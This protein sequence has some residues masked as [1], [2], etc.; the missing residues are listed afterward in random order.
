MQAQKKFNQVVANFEQWRRERTKRTN[1]P[2][3]LRQQAIELINEHPSDH[4]TKALRISTR[5]LRSWRDQLP[6]HPTIAPDFIPLPIEPEPQQAATHLSM[7]IMLP[8][9]SKIRLCGEISPDLLRT[10]IQEAG[11]R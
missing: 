9:S 8:N 3:G 5:Q 1:I 11:G 2:N 7:E 4:V 10:L 6:D